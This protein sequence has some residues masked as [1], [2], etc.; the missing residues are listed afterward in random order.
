MGYP[1]ED[2]YIKVA[3]LNP[4]YEKEQLVE[5]VADYLVGLQFW[6]EDEYQRIEGRNLDVDIPYQSQRL[7]W[8]LSTLINVRM[9]FEVKMC[10]YLTGKGNLNP[11]V[12]SDTGAVIDMYQSRE[13]RCGQYADELINLVKSKRTLRTEQSLMG[14]VADCQTI[15]DNPDF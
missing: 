14:L 5:L 7:C 3:R 13:A 12:N 9:P 15:S 1:Q 11:N 4:K 2:C 8:L 6:L 10:S